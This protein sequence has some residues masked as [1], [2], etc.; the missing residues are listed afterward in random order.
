MGSGDHAN[1]RVLIVDDQ[2][3]IHDDFGEML[4]PDDTE[5]QADELAA[6]FLPEDGDDDFPDFELLHAMSGEDACEVVRAAREENRPVA[7]AYVDVRMPP[8]H[9]RRRDDPPGPGDRP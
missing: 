9:R 1:N 2:P 4:T 8:G 5:S 3:E 7:L 6:A